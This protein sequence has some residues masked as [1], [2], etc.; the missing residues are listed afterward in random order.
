MRTAPVALAYLGDDEA[1][2]AAARSVAS[3][4]HADP[5]AGDSCVLWCIAIDRAVRDVRDGRFDGV[6]DGLALLP[7]ERRGYWA[8]ALAAAKEQP[9]SSF[10]NSG[11]TVTAL[12]AAYAAVVQI[13]IPVDRPARHLQD[14]LDAAVRIGHD[15]DTVAAIAGGL[16]GARWGASALP[17]MWRRMLHG[18]PGLRARDLVR[19]GV[20]TATRGR[21]TS[22]GWPAAPIIGGAG[23]PHYLVELPGDPGVLLGI[24]TSLSDALPH[25]DAVVSLCRVG[26]RQIPKHLEHHEAWLVDQSGTEANPNLAFVLDDVVDAI[27]LR[28]KPQ[29]EIQI[30]SEGGGSRQ[31]LLAALALAIAATTGRRSGVTRTVPIRA[32][33]K[34][35]ALPAL[36]DAVRVRTAA[37][38]ALQASEPTGDAHGLGRR[39][40]RW[41][42]AVDPRSGSGRHPRLPA[43]HP[44][45]GARDPA[46]P[47][48]LARDQTWG[49]THRRHPRARQPPRMHRG[50]AR[51]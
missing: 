22:N 47:S 25:V 33:G 15:T 42:A 13:P 48:I 20:L 16:L 43:R 39:D 18:W 17:F 1:I 2:A 4:T 24:L 34:P 11:F 3:L 29:A 8:N 41:P 51:R 37:D 46:R 9:P 7:E 44:R 28:A 26:A 35:V 32:S 45:R 40:R 14:A 50:V 36:R 10:S 19:L 30:R 12:Q 49:R 5:L 21:S 6:H 27:R 31:A 38:S 23:D